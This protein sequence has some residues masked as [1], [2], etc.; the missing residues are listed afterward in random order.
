M[1]LIMKNDKGLNDIGKELEE[2]FKS[3]VNQDS[4]SRFRVFQIRKKLIS[5][6]P[7]L[8]NVLITVGQRKELKLG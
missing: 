7:D 5:K 6:I 3:T 2:F 8:K 4:F 1:A